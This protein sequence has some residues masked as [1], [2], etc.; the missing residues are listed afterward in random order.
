MPNKKKK[1]NARFPPARIK[2]IMQT[3]EEVGKVAAAVPVII[4]RALEL[5]V[6][7]L[8]KK[9]S[10]ITQAKNAKTLTTT[11]LKQCI[12]AESQFDFLKDLV[13]MVPDVQG[14]DDSS[15]PPSGDVAKPFQNRLKKQRRRKGKIENDGTAGPSQVSFEESEEDDTEED[16]SD[17]EEEDES[18]DNSIPPK[19]Q[20]LNNQGFTNNVKNE[21]SPNGATPVIVSTRSFVKIETSS[22]QLDEDYDS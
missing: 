2:K 7:S 15:N 20:Y 18:E 21:A 6:E 16:E 9:A 8:I 14:D 22:T 11:H 5:F 13:A 1:Y 17:S 19:S 10:E 4:S 3:D 12:L